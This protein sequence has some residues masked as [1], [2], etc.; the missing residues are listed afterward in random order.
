MRDVWI[1]EVLTETLTIDVTNC[2]NVPRQIRGND[3]VATLDWDD[4]ELVDSRRIVRYDV[5]AK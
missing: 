5:K 4:C 2:D 3:W 1:T